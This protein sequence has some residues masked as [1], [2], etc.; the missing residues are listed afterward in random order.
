MY[1]PIMNP[2]M[3]RQRVNTQNDG[4]K[5]EA[6]LK[7]QQRKPQMNSGCFLPNLSDTILT[8]MLPRKNP[9]KITEVEMNPNEP[10]LHTRS[11]CRSSSK[12]IED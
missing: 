7:T 11:N 9:K 4:A 1:L 6:K 8:K 3:P 5:A 2:V 12:N 10:R